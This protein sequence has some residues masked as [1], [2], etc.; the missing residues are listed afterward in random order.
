LSQDAQGRV[1]VTRERRETLSAEYDR[2]WMS[3]VKFA[4]YVGIKGS[5][6]LRGTHDPFPQKIDVEG[7][8]PEVLQRRRQQRLKEKLLIKADADAKPG[9]SNGASKP[10]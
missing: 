1:L 5:R 2:S 9:R 10:D 6:R 8:E 4:E 7:A 3:G